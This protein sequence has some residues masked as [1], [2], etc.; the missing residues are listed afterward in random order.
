MSAAAPHGIIIVMAETF[1]R[2]NPEDAAELTR[3]RVVMFEGMGNDVSGLDE[4][5]RR[6]N[7]GY[8]RSRLRDTGEF[9]AF[10]VDKP[11][12]TGLAACAVGWLN[13][14]LLGMRNL[15]GRRGYIA[16]TCTDVGFRS[17]GYGRATVTQLVDWM[18]AAGVPVVDLHATPD[19]E[20]LYRSLGFTDPWAPALSLRL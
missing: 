15:T 16:N 3:L 12:G 4:T 2:A 19:G 10:V 13:P 5:W 9:A 20:P 18:R 1:R 8:F 14:H 17:R 7:A 6:Q 11:D